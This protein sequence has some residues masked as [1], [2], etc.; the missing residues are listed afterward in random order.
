MGFFS[1]LFGNTQSKPSQP[2]S[3]YLV[4]INKC[5]RYNLDTLIVFASS[6]C[7]YCSKY[8]RRKNGTGKIYSISGKKK[9]PSVTTIPVNLTG[10]ICPECGCHISYDPYFED[11]ASDKPLSKQELEEL[12]RI[13]K[14]KIK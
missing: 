8:G 2:T 10:G 4:A 14:S 3:P 12:D 5:K 7:P 9:Y 1:N 11:V 6:K 13:R